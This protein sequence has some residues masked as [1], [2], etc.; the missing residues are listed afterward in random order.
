MDRFGHP[1][2]QTSPVTYKIWANNSGGST[3]ATIN[4][5]INDQLP[6]LSY[7]STLILTN[8]IASST[9]LDPTFWLWLDFVLEISEPLPTD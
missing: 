9:S 1:N 4:I 8:N 7:S 2:T 5:T 3:N 6:T